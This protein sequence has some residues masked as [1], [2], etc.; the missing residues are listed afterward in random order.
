MVLAAFAYVSLPSINLP[1]VTGT[2]NTLDISLPAGFEIEVFAEGG[3]DKP[4]MMMYKD[5]VFYVSATKQGKVLT[6]FDEDMNGVAERTG[7]FIVDLRGPHGI[8]YDNGWF[9]IA[10]ENR[11]IR[12]KENSDHTADRNTIESLVDLPSG[13]GHST[14]TVKIREDKMYVSVGSSCNVCLEGQEWRASVIQCNL[15]GT[16]CRIFASGLRNSVGIVFHPQTGELYGT[17][18]GRDWLGNDLPPEEINIISDGKDYGWPICYGD[19]IHD[20][21][22]DKNVYIRNPCADTE[23][24]FAKMQAH[25]AP[26]GLSFYT[27]SSFPVEY[28]NKIFVAFHG[29]WNRNPPTGYKIVTVDLATREVKDFASGWLTSEGVSGRPVDIIE[30][31]GD[32]YVTDDASGNIYRIY[33]RG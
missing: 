7:T 31:N 19:K 33:Y 21:D 26:L 14:R 13:S 3:A 15:D 17:D 2:N 12:L 10:E 4:R 22:F 20:T 27:G 1:P 9:Y 18:N 6:I 11:V 23:N 30:V 8:D 32:L 16:G 29:S 25:S 24:P 5:G 28:R